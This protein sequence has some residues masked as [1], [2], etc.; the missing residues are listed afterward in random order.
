MSIDM[1]DDMS[2]DMVDDMSIDVVDD[3]SID[4][5]LMLSVQKCPPAKN[6]RWALYRIRKSEFTS[7][8]PC[9]VHHP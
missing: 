6:D 7:C 1:V 3:M 2:I 5:I 4:M 9:L 8:H